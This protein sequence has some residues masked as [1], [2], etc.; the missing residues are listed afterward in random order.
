MKKQ[1]KK[2]KLIGDFEPDFL[3]MLKSRSFLD[4]DDANSS[5]YDI[6]IISEYAGEEKS[7]YKTELLLLPEL[8]EYNIKI[9]CGVALN[10][11]MNP[12]ATI[13]Y[14][15]VDYETAILSINREVEVFNKNMIPQEIKTEY[16]QNFSIYNNL[17]I[18]ILDI[19]C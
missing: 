19:I 6:I 18:N 15:S 1:I 14:S 3:N 17:L 13:N 11:G 8:E 9:E 4:I 7:V 16:N 2:T 5:T 10:L 12:T